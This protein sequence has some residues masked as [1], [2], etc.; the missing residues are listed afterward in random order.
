MEPSFQGAAQPSVLERPFWM[1]DVL[2]VAL[3]LGGYGYDISPRAKR[4]GGRAFRSPR[5]LLETLGRV[6]R[7]LSGIRWQAIDRF[8]E[9]AHPPIHSR[10]RQAPAAAE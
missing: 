10:G 4:G 2:N 9:R 3:D 8:R 5:H 6:A 7:E 1:G